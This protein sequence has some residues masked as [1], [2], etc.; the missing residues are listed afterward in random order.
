LPAREL[1]SAVI[2]GSEI[3]KHFIKNGINMNKFSMVSYA[4]KQL[5]IGVNN[6]NDLY[7]LYDK[8]MA[9]INFNKNIK[10][11]KPKS[12]A[13]HFSLVIRYVSTNFPAA[14]VFNEIKKS[15]TNAQNCNPIDLEEYYKTLNLGKSAVD[16]RLLPVTPYLTSNKLTYCSKCYILGHTSLNCNSHHPKCRVCLGECANNHRNE[17]EGQFICAQCGGNHFSLDGNCPMVQKYRQELNKEVKQAIR[18]GV[19]NYNTQAKQIKKSNE[20]QYDVNTF[21]PLIQMDRNSEN[22]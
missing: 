10:V 12:I 19:L 11:I 13:A 14:F 15:I 21:P 2:A 5:K 9:I 3:Y 20:Y 1:P 22:R 18:N 16:N 8:Q 17:C 7:N 4:G 6:K